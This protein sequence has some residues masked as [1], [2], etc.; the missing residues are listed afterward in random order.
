MIDI[1]P[2]LYYT[3]L[4]IKTGIV[5]MA[6]YEKAQEAVIRALENMVGPEA[7]LNDNVYLA[8]LGIDS[9]DAIEMAMEIEEDLNLYIDDGDMCKCETI[10]DL[11]T[12]IDKQL[13][14]QQ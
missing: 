14:V 3:R 11:I 5:I 9:F 8:D 7:E 2:A 13:T 4:V 12:F 10:G 1:F 6:N